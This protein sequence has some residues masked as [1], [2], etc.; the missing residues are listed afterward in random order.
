MAQDDRTLGFYTQQ[1]S[2]YASRGDYLNLKH[3]ETFLSLLPA[4]AAILELGCGAGRDSEFMI[5]RGFKVRPTDGTPEMA[6]AAEQRLGMPVA[7]LLFADLN[8]ESTCDGIWANA[9]LLH[10]PREE[11]SGILSRI[12]AALRKGGAF[13][14]SFKAGE[15]EGRDQFNRYYNYP[16]GGTLRAWYAASDWADVTITAERGGGYDGRPTDWLHVVAIK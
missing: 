13:Y 4:G 5:G 14:A 2:A 16:S 1:A 7:T 15:T 6:Q 3:I 10:V 9:C 12:H 8:E 11:L